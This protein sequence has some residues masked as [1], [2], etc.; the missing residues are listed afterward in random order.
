MMSDILNSAMRAM[1]PAAAMTGSLSA[2]ATSSTAATAFFH[3]VLL[4]PARKIVGV[5]R[6]QHDMGLGPPP[7]D[8]ALAGAR[9]SGIGPCRFRS[10]VER[11][12]GA[13][14]ARQRAPARADRLDV[15]LGQ[16]IFIL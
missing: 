8:P 7:H 11:L 13:V 15:D 5:D 9:G 12:R 6:P 2:W 3:G 1:P 16:E 14:D 10:D 4:P